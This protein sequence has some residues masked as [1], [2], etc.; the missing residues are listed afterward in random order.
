MGTTIIDYEYS[1]MMM[2]FPLSVK[3]ILEQHPIKASAPCRI[4]SGGT[5][6]IKTMALP[7]QPMGPITIN[8]ALNL[9]TEVVVSAYEE[10]R[11]KVLSDGFDHSEEYSFDDLPLHPPFGFF[12]GAVAHFGYHGLQIRIRSGSPVQAAL[13]GSST[14]LVAL[15]KALYELSTLIHKGNKVY[16]KKDILHLG[17][18]LEDGISGG[19][20]GMQDQAAA[21]YGGVNQW[22]WHYANRMSVFRRE[23]L[24]DRKGQKEISRCLLVAYSG[25]NHSSSNMNHSWIKN[26]LSGKTRRGWIEANNIVRMFG[27][28]IKALDWEKAVKLLKSET[29]IRREITPDAFISI[30]E[31]LIDQAEKTGCAARFTGAG[32]GGSVWA[33]GEPSKL[34][35]TRVLWTKILAPNKTGMIMN[36]A[37]DSSGVK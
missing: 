14:A 32:G 28:A 35:E 8:M 1:Q 31:R 11:I 37:V 6:D 25:I 33:F 30:T 36:C 13:G 17:Y 22:E 15:I 19:N 4:D 29:E 20:C 23:S 26:F 3:N 12:F 9:R 34:E 27:Q 5:W 7:F 10:G 18:H 24:L 2:P 16:T 21:V